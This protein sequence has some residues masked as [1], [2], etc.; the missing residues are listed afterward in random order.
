[1]LRLLKAIPELLPR[2]TSKEKELERGVWSSVDLGNT[3]D[4]IIL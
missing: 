2:D 4:Y 3:E 1:M